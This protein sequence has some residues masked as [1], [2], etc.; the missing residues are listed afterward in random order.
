M[1]GPTRAVVVLKV[2]YIRILDVDIVY[3]ILLYQD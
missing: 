2:A 3:T 1:G